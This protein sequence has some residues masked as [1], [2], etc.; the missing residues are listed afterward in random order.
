MRRRLG[1]G[2]DVVSDL[3]LVGGIL[4]ETK[5]EWSCG[6]CGWMVLVGVGFEVKCK[7]G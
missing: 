5:A 4:V 1:V 2:V 7:S 3:V 6:L